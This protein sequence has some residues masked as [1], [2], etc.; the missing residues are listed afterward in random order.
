MPKEEIRAAIIHGLERGESIHDVVVSLL[1]AGYEKDEVLDV[2][3][4]F[5]LEKKGLKEEK[6]VGEVKVKEAQVPKPEIAIEK[7]EEKIKE[8]KLEKREE[9]KVER[10]K[11]EKAEKEKKRIE[12]E[13][14]VEKAEKE[15]PRTKLSITFFFSLLAFLLIFYYFIG[16]FIRFKVIYGYLLLGIPAFLLSAFLLTRLRLPLLFYAIGLVI[17]V[18]CIPAIFLLVMH[19]TNMKPEVV[20]KLLFFDKRYLYILWAYLCSYVFALVALILSI[21]AKTKEKM[22]KKQMQT[23]KQ[24]QQTKVEKEKAEKEK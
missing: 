1:Q 11:E 23:Q 17:C 10:K 2:A 12:M 21:I 16:L 20:F 8:E 22:G 9:T 13:E 15:K 6:E 3:N 19:L 7:K 18:A 14:K 4:E 24:M 5:L